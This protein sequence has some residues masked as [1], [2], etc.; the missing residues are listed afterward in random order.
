[1]PAVAD[2]K[3]TLGALLLG[4]FTAIALSGVVA[5]QTFLYF[6][7]YRKDILRIKAMVFIVWALDATHTC[8]VCFSIWDYVILN[9]GDAAIHDFIPT[10]V[11]L[12]VAMTALVTFITHLF[13]SHRVLRLSKNNW[14]LATPL[15]FLAICRLAAALVTTIEMGRL[16]SFHAY[17]SKFSSVFTLGLALSSALDVLIAF[18]MCFYLQTSR[19]GFGKMDHIIDL[20]MIYTFNNGAL[21]C[22]TTIISMICWLT[23][24]QNL[25]FMALH[26]AIS[27]LY[28]NSLLAT[29]NTRR[30][31][32]GHVQSSVGGDHDHPMPVLFP[33]SY[34]RRLAR[35]SRFPTGSAHTADDADQVGTK[36][37]TST[38]VQLDINTLTPLRPQQQ[39]QINVE[40]TIHYDVEGSPS[41]ISPL[42]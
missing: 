18:A 25:V 35:G 19:T 7:M 14:W 1:M 12:T 16:H 29:L 20:I 23:M 31:L 15:I 8:L 17:T 13:F 30:S 40:K 42:S 33:D 34:N 21:T 2:V 32:R 6:R 3:P 37:S 41:D 27:K 11:A 38:V 9:F 10:S 39:L 28:A 5:T 4:G 26:F 22:I 24:R 36:A